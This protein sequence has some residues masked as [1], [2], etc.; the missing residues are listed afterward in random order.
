MRSQARKGR[1]KKTSWEI[2]FY[3]IYLFCKLWKWCC[4][5]AVVVERWEG[6]NEISKIFVTLKRVWALGEH[7][8]SIKPGSGSRRIM[9]LF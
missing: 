3:L 4:L 1:E 9:L 8:E 7:K 5:L 2:T 6:R